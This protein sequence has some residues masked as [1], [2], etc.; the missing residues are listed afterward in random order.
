MNIQEF[1]VGII[2]STI[3]DIIKEEQIWNLYYTQQLIIAHEEDENQIFLLN[4]EFDER[5]FNEVIVHYKDKY[6]ENIVRIPN[7]TTDLKPLLKEQLL[8]LDLD[9]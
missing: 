6:P 2:A 7:D 4:S 9:F 3:K 1:E 8:K 5:D